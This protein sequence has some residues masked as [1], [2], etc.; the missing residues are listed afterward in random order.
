MDRVFSISALLVF[1]F[2]L[3]MLV[4]PRWR[5]TRKVLGSPAVV[6]GAVAL[7]AWLVVPALDIV[8]PVVVR[9]TL[10]TV[11]TLLNQPAAATAA[12]A[13]FLAFDLFV[14]RWI[15]LDAL[16]RN[17]PWPAVAATLVLTLL[18]GPLGLATYL[19]LRRAAWSRLLRLGR[20]LQAA[21]GPLTLIGVASLVLLGASLIL[22]TV[23]HRVVLGVST[24]VKPAKFAASVAIA[25][26]TLAWIMDQLD[27]R[28]P[29]LRRAAAII[30]SM[31]AVELA[32]I[33]IQ[34]ARGVPSHFNARTLVDVIAFAVM[35]V[36]ITIFWL[37]QGYV[38]FR[39]LRHRFT[40]AAVGWGIRLGLGIA[41]GAGAVA[42][43]M[44]QPTPAQRAALNLKS[45]AAVTATATAA[46]PALVGAHAVGV[47]DGGPGLP[48]TRWSTEG[49]D[50]RVPHFIGLHALQVLPLAGALFA[51]RRRRAIGRGADEPTAT[52]RANAYTLAVG[53]GYL[54]LTAVT[55]V[56]ALRAQPVLAPDGLTC[57]LAA[58]A[59]LPALAVAAAVHW[60]APGPLLRPRLALRKVWP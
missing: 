33:T 22:Q 42:F 8:L 26:F 4:A 5:V 24:W 18:L 45:T 54:G 11:M 41:L 58:L 29:G 60:R 13:H 2:W 12:W 43:L 14:G 25:A 30:A 57:A 9:P 19:V 32:I 46:Q 40:D 17:L 31:V 7:Y 15:Y 16:E 48:I 49:G 52:R 44:T 28:T 56:Q 23:D 34:A 51:R 3:A 50:L 35:G 36:G 39:A 10:A 6:L 20:D 53:I 59:A 47:P 55:L 1:P 27:G 37:A 21:N 38:F